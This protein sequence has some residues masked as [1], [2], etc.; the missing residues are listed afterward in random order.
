MKNITLILTF[1]LTIIFNNALSQSAEEK[2]LEII[3]KS[4]ALDNGFIDSTVEGKMILKDKSGNESVRS[5][6]NFIFEELDE[7]LGDKSIIVFSEPRDVKG[8][9]LLT[10]ANIEPKDDDQWLYLP[11][12]KRVKRISSS[13][14]TGKFVS[15]EFSYEDLSTD[16]P[17]DYNFVWLEE[18][19]CPADST[20]QCHV[21]EATPKNKKSGYSMRVIY[22]DID[23]LRY[24]TVKFHNRRGDL[25]KELNFK[26]YQKYL[27]KFWR[28]GILEMINLQTG[29]STII[30]WENYE[31]Q[32]NL[33]VNDFNPEKLAKMA[34]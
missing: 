17:K 15:S 8:T 19:V 28:A 9:S 22:I 13:N 26:N 5:F 33:S 18:V 21:I 32:T 24:Q 27:E 2:G 11:A 23:E 1:L 3:E 31:F 25:E 12:L 14:R 30:T 10:H 4:I 29:K 20:L 6:K 16:E 7:T 34:R